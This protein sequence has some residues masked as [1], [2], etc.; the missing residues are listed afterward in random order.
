MH[1]KLT[2]SVLSP[3][4]LPADVIKCLALGA[5]AV[6]VGRPLLWVSSQEGNVM[7]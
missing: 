2:L 4:G 6:L 7:P 5:S 3:P 1:P